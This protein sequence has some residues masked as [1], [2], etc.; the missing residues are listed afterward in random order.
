[1][2]MRHLIAVAAF[3]LFGPAFGAELSSACK[4]VLASIE[5]TLA[6]DHV[7]SSTQASSTVQ[8]I[9][10]GGVLYVQVRG[11]WR[12]SPAT[13]QGIIAQSRE[14]LKDAREFA[15]RPL[16]DS[17]VDGVP[18]LN[19][20][21]HTVSEDGDN[22]DGTVA[23]DKRNGLTVRVESHLNGGPDARHVTHYTYGNV[24]AP[25]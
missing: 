24:K 17:I 16:P 23:I 4:P 20:A 10:V 3:G 21:T 18:A 11:A 19:I 5:K 12:K 9:T 25:L 6:T 15:C 8:G 1:M 2:A 13:A 14:N 7:T 22:E